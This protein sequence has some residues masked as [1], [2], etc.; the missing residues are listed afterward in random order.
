M[1]NITKIKSILS[2]VTLALVFIVAGCSDDILNQTND[3]A[4]ST[5]N[6]GTSLEQVEAAV[7]GAFHPIT[8]TFFWG[9][10][11]HTGAMLRSD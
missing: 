9:R 6:F 7:N 4:T 2:V 3:N 11:V 8:G 1:K 5:G 10:I